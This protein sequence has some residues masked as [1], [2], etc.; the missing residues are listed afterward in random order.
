[1]RSNDSRNESPATQALILVRFVSHTANHVLSKQVPLMSIGEEIL[2][3]GVR[4]FD[5]ALFECRQPEH[6]HG[7][8]VHHHSVH[9]GIG[10]RVGQLVLHVAGEHHVSSF[11]ELVVVGKVEDV[12][13][14]RV[15]F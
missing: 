9:A 4:L 14:A 8:V 1:M 10:T 13:Q 7:T 12:R 11:K 15:R 3:A 5:K 6:G 2:Q